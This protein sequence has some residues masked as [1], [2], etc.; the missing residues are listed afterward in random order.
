MGSKA[1]AGHIQDYLDEEFGDNDGWDR[2]D[3]YEEINNYDD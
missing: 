3:D 2:D 1:R